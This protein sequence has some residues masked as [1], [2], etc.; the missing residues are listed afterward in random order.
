VLSPSHPRVLYAGKDVV[1]KS[2]DRGET[3]TATGG[4]RPLN[5]GLNNPTLSMAISWTDPDRV[6]A[7]TAPYKTGRQA[8]HRVR[9][10]RT[11]DGG[12]TW[13]DITGTLPDRFVMDI[14]VHPTDHDQVFLA[15]SGFGSSHVF[16][17]RDGGSS[18]QDLDQGNLPDVPT[19][20]LAHDPRDAEVLF[21]GND[22]GVFASPDRGETW[23]SLNDG[24][25]SAV[26]VFDLEV[27]PPER[28][29]R[30]GSHG[31]GVWEL[32]I[33][34]RFAPAPP[35]RVRGRIGN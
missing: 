34:D 21:V 12:G 31:N 6:Y 2:T 23:Y 19:N 14:M 1:F 28:L 18:W 5:P 7:A 27:F 15:L 25:P 33:P 11:D 35:R 29:R 9:V 30:A 17:S 32:R 16:A 4:G 3:W 10:Y 13:E 22:I 20:A 26:M 24:L 8:H